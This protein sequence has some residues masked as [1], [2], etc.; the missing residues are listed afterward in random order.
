MLMYIITVFDADV[1]YKSML[2]TI[3]L[4]IL[5]QGHLDLWI[6]QGNWV[7]I[8]QFPS[9]HR[10]ENTAGD[11]PTRRMASL[12]YLSMVL[13]TVSVAQATKH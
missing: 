1:C 13:L 4:T 8:L 2:A 5:R 3:L 6:Q 11:N 9:T 7:Q 12:I 10:T